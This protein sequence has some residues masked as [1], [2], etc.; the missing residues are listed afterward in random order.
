MSKLKLPAAKYAT[1]LLAC[2]MLPG[3]SSLQ[4]SL[5]SL[6]P[7][8][9]SGTNQADYRNGAVKIPTLEVP[10]D[11][12]APVADDRFVI[13]DP[14]GSTSYSTYNKERSTQ[15]TVT[16]TAVLPKV[17][18]VQI[19][20]D[21]TQR[22]LTVKLPPD[23]VWPVVKT[24]WQ[25]SGFQ[26]VRDM[27][28]AGILETDWAENRAKIQ[29]DILRNTIGRV[30]DGLYSTGER[31]KFRTRVEAGS[32]PG[33]ADIY[34]SHRGLQEVLTSDKLA[35]VWQAR[36]NDPDLELEMM[37]RL[38]VRLGVSEKAA[39]TAVASGGTAA[40]ASPARA[41]YDSAKGGKLTINEAFDRAWR[42][43]GLALDRVGFTVEDRDRSKGLF[44]V[45]Y[46]DPDVDARGNPSKHW[47]S[48]MMFW[49]SDSPDKLP[50]YRIYVSDASSNGITSVEVQ[51]STGK[52]DGDSAT[53]KRILGLL[54]EQLK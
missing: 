42:R 32:E 7:F 3:C 40:A 34:V 53:A 15:P 9:G 41:S 37:S 1:L 43:I 45:R 51:D 5:Q 19:T 48:W 20:K 50:Q 35:T 29:Q 30:L 21:G 36:P 13:P 46:I 2:V 49:R 23:K 22:W 39:T 12:T 14:K 52:P 28:E 24:F 47:Y 31:D 6:W 4:Q 18:G 27:P 16:S 11:L 26:L 54:L 33:T 10:P 38:M 17:E 8:K 25:E 44:F